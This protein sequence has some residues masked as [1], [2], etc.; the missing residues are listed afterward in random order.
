MYNNSKYN[1]KILFSPSIVAPPYSRV[2]G[3]NKLESTLHEDT[4]TQVSADW[5]LRRFLKLTLYI[6]MLNFD[7]PLCPH[8]TRGGHDFYDFEST[9]PWDASKHKFQPSWLNDF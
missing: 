1:S 9:L 6:P 4:S 2:N 7:H 8:P 3:F 5:F